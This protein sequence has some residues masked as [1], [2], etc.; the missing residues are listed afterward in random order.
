MSYLGEAFQITGE[1]ERDKKKLAVTVEKQSRLIDCLIRPGLTAEQNEN[2]SLILE[3]II[4][5]VADCSFQIGYN[6]A[7]QTFSEAAALVDPMS[8]SGWPQT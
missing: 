7:M 6:S 3:E 2:L 5:T 1:I 8:I 4:S